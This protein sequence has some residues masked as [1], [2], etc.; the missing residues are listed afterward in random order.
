MPNPA[1]GSPEIHGY[2]AHVYY[3]QTTAAAA[4]KL[5]DALAEN[6]PI[7]V[8]QLRDDHDLGACDESMNY[9]G[10]HPIIEAW[11]DSRFAGPTD[12]QAAGWPAIVVTC[13]VARSICRI[14][15]LPISETNRCVPSVASARGHS[16][17]AAVPTPSIEPS[18]PPANVVVAVEVR[19]IARIAKLAESAT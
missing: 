3:N 1:T 12:A 4:V 15:L 18:V 13:F 16:N 9:F 14:A 17:C 8:G 2:H 11:F 10:F 6:F 5:H 7:E 19:S